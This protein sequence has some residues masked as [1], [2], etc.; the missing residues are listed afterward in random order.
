M[1]TCRKRNAREVKVII[2]TPRTIK[3]QKH[4]K[5]FYNQSSIPKNVAVSEQYFLKSEYHYVIP[6]T[7][8]HSATDN[9]LR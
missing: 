5:I 2:L 8:L 9:S 7:D 3:I 6:L 1:S 4:I